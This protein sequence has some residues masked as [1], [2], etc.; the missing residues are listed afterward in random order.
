MSELKLGKKPADHEAVRLGLQLRSF[1]D[2]SQDPPLLIGR[3]NLIRAWGMLGND[4]V[5]DCVWADAAHGT[6]QWRAAANVDVPAF[7]DQ[8]VI[9]AYAA[10]TG[11]DPADSSTDNGTGMQEAIARLRGSLIVQGHGT[12]LKE[13][14][15]C[16][17]AMYASWRLLSII[18]GS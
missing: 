5:A 9:D 18:L 16:G 14:W 17:R 10:V 6:M 2:V 12:R 8:N 4:Q 15:P 11:Y 7:T 3:V 13:A 1:V